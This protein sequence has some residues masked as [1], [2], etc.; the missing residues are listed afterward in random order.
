MR[1]VYTD[2]KR[3]RQRAFSTKTKTGA[4]YSVSELES[5]NIIYLFIY[6][7]YQSTA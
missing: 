6:F 7:I 4:M 1:P 2:R 5:Y 3:R